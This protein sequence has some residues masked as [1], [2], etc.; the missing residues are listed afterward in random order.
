MKPKVEIKPWKRDDGRYAFQIF[1]DDQAQDFIA[2]IN[3]EDR[4]I[5]RCSSGDLTPGSVYSLEEC[6]GN[7]NWMNR[8][9]KEGRL[10]NTQIRDSESKDNR[11]K[12]NDKRSVS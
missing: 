5:T 10:A 9:I 1:V 3:N 7:C 4:S 8:E 11:G 12:R 6:E 2:W